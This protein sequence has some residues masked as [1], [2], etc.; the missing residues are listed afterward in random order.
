[1]VERLYIRERSYSTLEWQDDI[2]GSQWLEVLHPFTAVKNLYLSKG[3]APRIAPSLQELVGGR[4]TEVLPALQRLCLD[5]HPGPFE[6]AIEKFVA[7]RRLSNHPVAVSQ[8]KLV[9]R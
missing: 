7:A 8:V 1:M 3:F 2:E 9:K 6:E 4:T 5:E